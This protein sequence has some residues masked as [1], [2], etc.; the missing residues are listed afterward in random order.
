MK[1]KIE[2]MTVHEA[3]MEM[4]GLGIQTSE[5]K[6]R[7]GIAQG[8][9]PWGICINMKTQEF[10]IYRTLFDDWVAERLSTK[11]EKYWDAV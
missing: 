1:P 8:K 11:P 7:A 2:T 3:C 10:E 4:R 5:N 9:Y 6:I